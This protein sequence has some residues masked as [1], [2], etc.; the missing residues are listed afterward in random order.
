MQNISL[1]GGAGKDGAVSRLGFRES[2]GVVEIQRLLDR[3]W[4]YAHASNLKAL[5]K[6]N[7][8]FLA[9]DYLAQTGLVYPV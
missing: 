9:N 6:E 5:G 1:I 8:H 7:Q 2:A 4:I 3:F